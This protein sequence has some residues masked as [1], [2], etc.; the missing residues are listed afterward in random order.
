MEDE[1][2]LEILRLIKGKPT[3]IKDHS[4]TR[5]SHTV[6]PSR[7]FQVKTVPLCCRA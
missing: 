7:S 5:G 2:A 6:E 3:A 1:I 4:D